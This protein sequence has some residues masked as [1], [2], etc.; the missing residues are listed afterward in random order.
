[1]CNTG[2]EELLLLVRQIARCEAAEEQETV[3]WLNEDANMEKEMYVVE[4]IC[5]IDE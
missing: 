4:I 5:S 3:E 1:M 2:E